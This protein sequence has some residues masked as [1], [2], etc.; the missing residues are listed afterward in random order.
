M[1]DRNTVLRAHEWVEERLSEYMDN[2]LDPLER[3]RLERHLE[4]C[5]RCQR[6]LDTLRWT[7]SVLKQAHAPALPRQ[8]TL[9]APARSTRAP[10][11]GLSVLRLATAL[12]TLILV[13][14]I[15]IDLITNL[16][17]GAPMLAPLPAAQSS[18]RGAEPAATRAALVP[19]PSPSGTNDLAATGLSA[20]A[21]PPLP[22]VQPPAPQL[23][24]N[25]PTLEP[26]GGP[27]P[28]FVPSTGALPTVPALAAATA[29]PSPT[30]PPRLF[31]G[32]SST[33]SAPQPTSFP[34]PT[35]P[36]F[37]LGGGPPPTTLPKAGSS[38]ART[39]PTATLTA[40]AE[41][42]ATL[43]PPTETPVP[44]TSTPTPRAQALVQATR[45]PAV[46]P[47]EPP[48]ASPEIVTPL[49]AA[50]LGALFV[51]VFLGAILILSRA[52]R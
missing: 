9:P 11:M 31:S 32:P 49:R 1:N 18:A 33:R 37:G 13:S 7:V 48:P 43:I 21:A 20:T 39:Q 24:P 45:V 38:E 30:L 12:A 29:A 41:P 47:P 44:P 27:L 10:A 6:S 34:S 5:T 36:A 17:G 42:T 23:Q 16:G 4:D 19:P 50:E 46:V 26:T 51:A 15:G 25:S 2:R 40:T 22:P 3:V 28:T 52:R 35:L 14:L 8:F